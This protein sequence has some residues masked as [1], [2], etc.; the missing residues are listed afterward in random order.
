MGYWEVTKLTPEGNT[1]CM[2][3]LLSYSLLTSALEFA[4]QILVFK[5]QDNLLLQ[6][7]VTYKIVGRF[8]S[9][10]YIKDHLNRTPFFWAETVLEEDDWGGWFIRKKPCMAIHEE[11]PGAGVA[12]DQDGSMRM[13]W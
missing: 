7:H 13:F 1:L 6:T 10:D 12:G 4:T 5:N 11:E 9:R 2:Q 3:V 8:S